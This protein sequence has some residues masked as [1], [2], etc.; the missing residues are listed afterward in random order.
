ML[1]GGIRGA[2]HAALRNPDCLRAADSVPANIVEGSESRPLRNFG[3][4]LRIA[5]QLDNRSRVPPDVLPATG[6]EVIRDSDSL[7]LR[8]QV[9]E[10]RKTLYGLIRH[11]ASRS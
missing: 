10:V 5:P 2:R 8:S 1:A 11:L 6:R 3:R 4:F 9:I 7:T